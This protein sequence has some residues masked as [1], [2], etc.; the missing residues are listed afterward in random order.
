MANDT[1]TSNLVAFLF[2]EDPKSERSHYASACNRVETN[3]QP[4]DLLISS[5]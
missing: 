3:Q 2:S 5:M 4:Q 1:V